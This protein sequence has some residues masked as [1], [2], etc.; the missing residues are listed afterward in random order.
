MSIEK[1]RKISYILNTIETSKNDSSQF[2]V[3]LASFLC[4]SA[5]NYTQISLYNEILSNVNPHNTNE[6]IQQ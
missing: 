4:D 5:Y 1:S 6:K 3:L 2:F